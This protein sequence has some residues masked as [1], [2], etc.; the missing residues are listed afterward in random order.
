MK[1]ALMLLAGFLLIFA[2]IPSA[3]AAVAKKSCIC[4]KHYAPVCGIKRGAVRATTFGN[5][6]MAKC[7][8]VKICAKGKCPSCPIFRLA[9]PR[10]GCK[11]VWYWKGCCRYPRLICKHQKPYCTKLKCVKCSKR[12]IIKKRRC[13]DRAKK[14]GPKHVQIMRKRC[15]NAR[16]RA[17]HK[18]ICAWAFRKAASHIIL[19]GMRRCLFQRCKKMKCCKKGRKLCI[20]HRPGVLCKKAPCCRK[21]VCAPRRCH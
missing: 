11:Y 19:A 2:A 4:T 10:P 12:C 18:C 16:F 14:F 9:R 17:K 1:K 5:Y 15:A 20:P 8:R 13:F 7:A 3:S 6:C 21:L